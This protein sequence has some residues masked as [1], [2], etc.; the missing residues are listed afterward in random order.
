MYITCT[1]SIVFS[2]LVCG[3]TVLQ[4][5]AKH[6]SVVKTSDL[7]HELCMVLVHGYEMLPILL[8]VLFLINE[9]QMPSATLPIE[10]I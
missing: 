10:G 6:M 7:H 9:Y 1:H 8:Y 3:S 2:V 4:L 5:W